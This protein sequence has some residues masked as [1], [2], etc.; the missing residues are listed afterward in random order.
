[1]NYH[2]AFEWGT[3]TQIHHLHISKYISKTPSSVAFCGIITCPMIPCSM[4]GKRKNSLI[5]FCVHIRANWDDSIYY[6]KHLQKVCK[7]ICIPSRTLNICKWDA[8][9][10]FLFA[11][12]RGLYQYLCAVQTFTLTKHRRAHGHT[13]FNCPWW[14][15]CFYGNSLKASR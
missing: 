7:N 12:G 9:L 2:P 14:N 13:H 3:L 5:T 11:H 10:M 6:V 15:L 8:R 1:M 4:R